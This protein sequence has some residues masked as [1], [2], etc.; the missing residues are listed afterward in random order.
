MK[1]LLPNH[2][3]TNVQHIYIHTILARPRKCVYMLLLFPLSMTCYI[4]YD[5]DNGFIYGM[6]M[7]TVLY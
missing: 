1:K 6:I 4:W 7:I 5:N 3:P 2:L